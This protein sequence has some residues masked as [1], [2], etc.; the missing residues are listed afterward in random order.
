M[1]LHISVVPA[2]TSM[3][4][5]PVVNRIYREGTVSQIFL[6]NSWFLFCGK[7]RE[8]CS[9]Y[10]PSVY[11]KFHKM[12]TMTLIKILRHRSLHIDGKMMQ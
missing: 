7:K 1:N 3:T 5:L 8:T 4:F 6:Y 9:H 11:S 10:F 12:Q 2:F